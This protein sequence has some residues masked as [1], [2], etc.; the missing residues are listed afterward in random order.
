MQA[1]TNHADLN[2]IYYSP[3]GEGHYD[4]TDAWSYSSN[5]SLKFSFLNLS[6]AHLLL[7]R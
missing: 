6:F 4:T 1:E 3:I 7:A 2:P 5:V